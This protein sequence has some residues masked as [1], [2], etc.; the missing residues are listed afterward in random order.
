M[1]FQITGPGWEMAT[2]AMLDNAV[3]VTGDLENVRS[4]IHQ[5]QF[6][7]LADML[8]EDRFNFTEFVTDAVLVVS[9][10][11]PQLWFK[12]SMVQ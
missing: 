1:S 10:N 9:D 6:N 7:E 12:T 11:Q 4:L 8:D 2:Q 3:V 5:R